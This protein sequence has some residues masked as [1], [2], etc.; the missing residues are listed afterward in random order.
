MILNWEE[1]VP[2]GNYR[3][4]VFRK[5]TVTMVFD[6]IAELQS[7]P[8]IITH[9]YTD[10]GLVNGSPYCYYIKSVGSYGSPGILDTLINLSQQVCA[11]PV[12]NVPPCAPQ[13]TVMSDCVA[14]AN[15]L[16]WTNPAVA[17]GD[18]D[19]AKYYIYFSHDSSTFEIIATVS[20]A[21]SITFVHSGLSSLSGCYKVTAVDF[22][23]N[24]STAD[25]F[26]VD[27]CREYVL[28]SV[29]TPN[30]DGNNDFFHPCD[31]TTSEQLQKKNCPPY[32]NVK[33][34]DIKIF[35]RWGVLVFETTDKNINWD[36]RNQKSHGECPDG[37]YYYTCEV[38]FFRFHGTE[39]KE[40]HGYV[41]LLREK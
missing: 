3:Y 7:S 15:R 39:T 21:D 27:T 33:D 35:D 19:V 30:G 29:F 5:D 36:G 24:E 18:S 34:I 38:N 25:I 8:N 26:C 10:T 23:G 13:L 9:T 31:S 41:H 40:L 20:P 22:V 17:C 32:K 14:E 1:H 37:V 11:K 4:V 16:S 12:D 6:S 28:P 2:W